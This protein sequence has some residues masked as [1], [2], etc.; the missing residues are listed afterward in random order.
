VDRAAREEADKKFKNEII[1]TD[2]WDRDE[3]EKYFFKELM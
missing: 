3:Y 1:W 2:S